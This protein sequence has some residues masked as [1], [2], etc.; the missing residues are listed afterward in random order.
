MNNLN[1][2][3]ILVT[4]LLFVFFL[5]QWFRHRSFLFNLGQITSHFFCLF[6]LIKLCRL[7]CVFAYVVCNFLAWNY[8]KVCKYNFGFLHLFWNFV[9][10]W[11]FFLFFLLFPIFFCFFRNYHVTCLR[12]FLNLVL[13][14][15]CRL[16]PWFWFF[17]LSWLNSCLFL[18]TCFRSRLWF[19]FLNY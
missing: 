4:S 14:R 9:R 17:F 8:L 1:I 19:F 3:V 12:S 7:F 6:S 18:L 5:R 16:R 13:F 10:G 15:L 2:F 11:P